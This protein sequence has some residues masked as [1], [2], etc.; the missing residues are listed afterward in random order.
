MMASLTLNAA[1]NLRRSHEMLVTNGL[2]SVGRPA[3]SRSYW[4]NARA[5]EGK[6]AK[7]S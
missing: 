3:S 2:E 6:P 4:A 5:G 7:N 1:S